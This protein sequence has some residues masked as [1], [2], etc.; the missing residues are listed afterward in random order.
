[1][2]ESIKTIVSNEAILNVIDDTAK[3]Y[4]LLYLL[5]REVSLLL[6]AAQFHIVMMMETLDLM[7]GALVLSINW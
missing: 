4:R 6:N 5:A 7:T 1:V 3:H 2:S